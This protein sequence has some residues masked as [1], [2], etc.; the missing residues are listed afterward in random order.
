MNSFVD[1]LGEISNILQHLYDLHVFFF[2]HHAGDFHN[3]ASVDLLDQGE[4]FLTQHLLLVLGREGGQ[5]G[6]PVN[7][8]EKSVDSF[9]GLSLVLSDLD[10]Q[11]LYLLLGTNPDIVDRSCPL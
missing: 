8:V 3:K 7:F 6:N 11:F 4:Q 2:Q 5:L 10:L 1:L 9:I